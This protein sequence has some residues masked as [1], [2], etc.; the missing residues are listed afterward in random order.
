MK[1]NTHDEPTFSALKYSSKKPEKMY[2]IT[3]HGSCM[4]TRVVK[5]QNFTAP[6]APCKILG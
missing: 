4:G 5:L 6:E 2:G 1:N 3:L